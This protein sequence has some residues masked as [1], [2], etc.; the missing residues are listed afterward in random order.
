[1]SR[2]IDLIKSEVETLK[3][4]K[5]ITSSSI[6]IQCPYHEDNTPSGGINIDATKTIP[7]GW[8]SCF[9]CKKSVPWN[10]LAKTLGLRQLKA[11]SQTNVTS[12]DY[13]D[14]S[15]VRSELLGEDENCTEEAEKKKIQQD[16]EDLDFFDF[17]PEVSKWRGFST[18]FLASLGA[19]YAYHDKSGEFLIWFPCMVNGQQVGYVKA[20]L[21]K[22]QGRPSYINSPGKWSRTVG[23]LFF[24]S[25]IKMMEE[26]GHTT[27]VLVEGPRDAL[28][29]LRFGIPTVCILGT[30]S[31][32]EDKRICLENAGVENVVIF[33]DGDK[34]DKNG[35][36]P[37]KT[38]TQMLV[39]SVKGYLG[40]KYV[41]MWKYGEGW[42]PGNC[43]KRFLSL[44]KSSLK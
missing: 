28:R 32:S 7:T 35:I 36:I 6:F 14:P 11:R 24:D 15:K 20:F 40:Y 23:L 10:T 22:V 27:I 1:M 13:I 5:T 43:P 41:N 2:A 42:D 21:E 34:P 16:L 25:A 29:C 18:T 9:G 39:R 30:R 3:V 26:Q 8:F 12:A 38:A 33:M 37:G 44:V 19:K 17:P 4:R 31:W